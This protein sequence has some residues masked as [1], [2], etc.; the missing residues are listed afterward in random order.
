MQMTSEKSMSDRYVVDLETGG[1]ETESTH[2][3]KELKKFDGEGDDDE[4]MVDENAS[5]STGSFSKTSTVA[6]KRNVSRDFEFRPTQVGSILLF[7]MHP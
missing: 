2:S 3:S 1:G 5:V 7:W 6:N 4:A